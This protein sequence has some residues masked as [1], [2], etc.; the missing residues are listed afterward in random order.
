MSFSLGFSLSP[1]GSS[2]GPAGTGKGQ[3]R[4]H[5][6][7]AGK[8]TSGPGTEAPSPTPAGT[9]S[10]TNINLCQG[11]LPRPPDPC[12]PSPSLTA[13]PSPSEERVSSPCPLQPSAP[14]LPLT[15]LKTFNPHRVAP[16]LPAYPSGTRPTHIFPNLGPRK[17]K[18]KAVSSSSGL[19]GAWGWFLVRV[20]GLWRKRWQWLEVEIGIKVTESKQNFPPARLLQISF[21]TLI[22][23]VPQAP[24]HRAF[25]KL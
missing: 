7:R 19:G 11:R 9:L 2:P 5:L 1:G 16:D 22:S 17:G 25:L 12:M 10:E 23:L 21:S 18:D 13:Q 15:G 20:G 3:R 4:P 6:E 14:S 8:T 24:Y